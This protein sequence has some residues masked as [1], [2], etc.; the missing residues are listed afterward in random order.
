MGKDDLL[1]VVP[2]GL[3]CQLHRQ[4]S[5]V[6]VQ[7][8]SMRLKTALIFCFEKFNI[9]L[10][11]IEIMTLLGY[12]VGNNAEMFLTATKWQGG[13]MFKLLRVAEFA[14]ASLVLSGAILGTWALRD[15]FAIFPIVATITYTITE[16]IIVFG[17]CWHICRAIRGR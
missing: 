15:M 6:T 2:I 11:Y 7:K 17:S 4:I 5:G 14:A 9:Y 12:R 16:G 13:I 8:Q 3:L 10:F 1:G